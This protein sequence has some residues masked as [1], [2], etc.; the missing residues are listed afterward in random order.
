MLRGGSE[1]I[2]LEFMSEN[3]W[4]MF[5]YKSFIVSSL[6]HRSLIHFVFIFMYGVRVF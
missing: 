3:V 4:P 2:L 1:K 5:S 6:T